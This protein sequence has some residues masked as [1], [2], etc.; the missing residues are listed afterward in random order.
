MESGRQKI[1][2]A[3]NKKKWK[4]KNVC[5]AKVTLNEG[6]KEI[7]KVIPI[8]KIPQES[9]DSESETEESD[10]IPSVTTTKKKKLLA[11]GT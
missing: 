10:T 1:R 8:K 5:E 4:I 2:S 6:N 7:I 3:Y 11:Y 9:S